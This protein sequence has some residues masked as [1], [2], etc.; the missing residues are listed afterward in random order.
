MH[1]PHIFIGKKGLFIESAFRS[2]HNSICSSRFLGDSG[3]KIGGKGCLHASL[4]QPIGINARL[5]ERTRLKPQPDEIMNSRLLY[6][7]VLTVLLGGLLMSAAPEPSMTTRTQ[8]SFFDRLV[9]PEITR[10]TLTFDI[11][12]LSDMKRSDEYFP[13]T[14]SHNGEKWDAEIKVRGRY[15]RRVCD[16]PP[17]KLKLNKDMLEAAGLQRHNKFKLV[18]HCSDNFDNDDNVL[19][20]HMAYELY[21]LMTGEGYRTQLVEV[22][23]RH[24]YT[25]ESVKRYGILIED[26]DEMAQANGGEECDDCFNIDAD[27]YEEGTREQVAMFQ[28]MIGNSDYGIRTPR[29]TKHV[30]Q[31]AG[32]AF[33]VV[34]YDFDFSGLVNAEYA[35]PNPNYQQESITDRVFVWEYNQA[36]QL[37]ATIQQ[38]LAKEDAAISLVENFPNLTKRSKREITKYLGEFFDSLRDGTFQTGV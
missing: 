26:T 20:E 7:A 11:D 4:L 23:Y 5:Y 35:I 24:A 10:F 9:T 19:R 29:N 13:A 30:Q 28:Y 3:N 25:G 14:F 6:A 12:G 34:P 18:T 37:D 16:F 1:T 8:Q 2:L 17:L 21:N 38:F 32:G 27:R 22:T 31:Q 36:P 15:R 33:K